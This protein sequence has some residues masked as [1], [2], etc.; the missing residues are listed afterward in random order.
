MIRPIS[1]ITSKLSLRGIRLPIAVGESL[2]HSLRGDYFENSNKN[3]H[4][5]YIQHRN[6]HLSRRN[7]SIV[8]A[9]LG[10]FVGAVTLQ[11]GLEAY[12]AYKA[13]KPAQENNTNE[14]KSDGSEATS[15]QSES[16]KSGTTGASGGSSNSFSFGSD[17]FAKTFY[18]NIYI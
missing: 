3:R 16:R 17:W 10:I 7:E 4:Q 5:H 9:G 11:Y 18:G 13:N 2:I 8:L 14:K 1:S 15:N 12:E 6:Y